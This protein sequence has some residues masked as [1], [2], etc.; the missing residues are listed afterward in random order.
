MKS[1]AKLWIIVLVVLSIV[2]GSTAFSQTNDTEDRT[3]SPYFFIRSGDPDVDRLP[4]KSTSASVRITGVIADVLVTQ[5]YK[6]E[7]RKS[8]E[9]VYVFPASTRAAVYGMKMTIGER[10]IEAKIKKRDEARREYEQALNDGKT[11]SL[12]EQQRPNVF[13]MNVANILPGDEIRVELAYTEL[14]VPTDRVY[15]FVYP[16]VVGPRYTNQPAESS[17]PSETWSRNPHLQQGEAP[18]YRFSIDVAIAAGLPIRDIHCTSHKVE[19]AFSSQIAAKI[20]LDPSETSGGNRDFILRYRLDGDR[21]QSGLLLYEGEREN[22]FLLMMQPPRKV[23]PMDIPGREYIFIIDVSGSM[24][25]F[26]LEISKKLLGDLIGSLRPTDRFNVLLFSGGSSVLS[27]ESL[28]ANPGNIARAIQ[29]IDRQRGGGGTEILPALKRALA[30][31]KRENVARTVVIATDGYVTVEEEVFDLIR[32]NLG[33]ANMFAFGIGSGVNRHI[34]EG[35]AR[36]GMGEPFV[37]TKPEEAKAKAEKFRSLIASPVLTG[38][39]VDFNG[40]KVYDVEPATIPDVLAERPVIVFGKWR[41]K[42]QG[43][44]TLSG[45]SGDRKYRETLDIG[46]VK[47]ARENAALRYLWARHRIMLLSDYNRLRISDS[48]IREATELG[49]THNLLTAYTSFVAVDTEVRNSD[50]RSVRVQQPLPLPQ[51][52]SNYALGGMTAQA[53]APLSLMQRK[54]MATPS[55]DKLQMD[56]RRLKVEEKGKTSSL[57]VENISVSS[58]LS[59]DTIDRV[60][61]DQLQGLKNC[62]GKDRGGKIVLQLTVRPD[63]AVKEVQILSGPFRS[64]KNRLCLIAHVKTWSFPALPDGCEVKVTITL[65]VQT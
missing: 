54:E 20:T 26:P 47:P 16:T 65:N 3:L 63:G 15:A 53:A 4:L 60:V 34:I 31:P 17:P 41:G 52:V 39:K 50:G 11:A 21:I 62:L 43:R 46:N 64:E 6:N 32:N 29:L 13:Q 7:G 51:G 5:V 33:N 8:L 30:L 44:I 58:G 12:L 25:G 22:Y 2:P 10:V 35:M 9:A 55:E 23:T 14:I 61:Q 42:P 36:V 45:F 48:R 24:H 37:I 19:T 18:T 28:P 38:V 40:F 49:L 56:A 1:A 57:T 59:K 27:E